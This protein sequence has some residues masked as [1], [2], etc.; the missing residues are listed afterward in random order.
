MAKEK[1]KKAVFHPIPAWT[2]E[3][4]QGLAYWIG[5]R[6]SYYRH[7]PLLEGAIT[8]E[9]CNLL[10]GKLDH[11]SDGRLFCE[12]P[13]KN[14]YLES[15]TRGEPDAIRIDLLI[16]E[17]NA[18]IKDARKHIFLDTA[19]IAIEVKR[20][21]A[22]TFEITKDLFRLANLNAMRPDI[23]TF[24]LIVSESKLP[25]QYDWFSDPKDGD[26]V[27]AA[28]NPIS[29]DGA[30]SVMKVRRICKAMGSL[31]A[32]AFHSAILIEVVSL[33]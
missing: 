7:Y 31:K 19:K 11:H 32:K 33:D 14:T 20:G 25:S 6:R 8:A 16:A 2:D 17:E 13:Y 29:I 12:V 22:S 23:R 5:Y 15:L 4:L 21:N 26:D 1:V 30:N 18:P 10:N 27:S 3:V 28:R 24:L 9:L